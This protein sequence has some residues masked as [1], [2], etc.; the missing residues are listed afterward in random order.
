MDMD[1]KII[2]KKKEYGGEAEGE[3]SAY[4]RPRSD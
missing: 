4:I 1:I 3:T 2:R